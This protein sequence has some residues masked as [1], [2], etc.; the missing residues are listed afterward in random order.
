MATLTSPITKQNIVD[1]FA[2]YVV[3]T[4]NAGIVWHSTNK[5]FPEFDVN[6]LGASTGLTIGITG[7][8]IDA[9]PITA[10]TIY[11]ALVAET[12]RYTR[13]RSLRATLTITDPGYA[14]GGNSTRLSTDA[15][16][17]TNIAHLSA[18]Y[19]QSIGSPNNGGVATGQ[20]ISV[21]NLQTLFGNLQTAY[22]TARATSTLINVSVCHSSC[23]ASC[24]GSRGRR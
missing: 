16:D 7:A 23:H 2:D 4:A 3:A 8:N 18:A 17:L 24:H 14:I 19:A 6:L 20:S 1:R 5:P 11:N 13:I 9:A 10:S 12:N 21:T 22:N 15:L